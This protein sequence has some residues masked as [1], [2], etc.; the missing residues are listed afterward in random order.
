MTRD[1]PGEQWKV[2]KF[3]FEYTNSGTIE[4]SNFG[5]VRT[6]NKISEGN[7]LKG[8]MI[9]GYKIMRLKLYSPRPDSKQSSL[10]AEQRSV[11]KMGKNLRQMKLDKVAK[12][13]IKEYQLAYD[14][15]KKSLSK[16]FNADLKKRTLH[17]HYL[18]HRMVADY[19]L[20]R[21]KATQTIVAHLDFDKLNNKVDNLKWMTP[22]ENYAHQLLSPY[23]IK[24]KRDRKTRPKELHPNTKL[25]TTKVM[26]LKKLLLQEK[27]MKQLVKQFKVTETQILRIKRGENWGDVQAA[28]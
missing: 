23:V 14:E 18:F 3:D 19:F 15:K 27:P 6:F 17:C 8:S 21:P 25:T 10:D 7:L 26:L 9:N 11:A 20:P 28:K 12:S 4:V 13:E 24:E 2:I 5:R 16:K 1:Y 22:E